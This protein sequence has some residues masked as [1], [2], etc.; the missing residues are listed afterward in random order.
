MAGEAPCP[1][2]GEAGEAA[3]TAAAQTAM[4]DAHW[5]RDGGPTAEEAPP[6]A[7]GCGDAPPTAK[8]CGD[9]PPPD[10]AL[11]DRGAE[12]QR[13]EEAAAAKAHRALRRER[14]A[15]YPATWAALLQ[16]RK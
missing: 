5:G 8:G 7:K 9:A 10:D 15:R 11:A 6:T 3:A 14:E 16:A 2:A 1:A 13:R 12:A 4:L